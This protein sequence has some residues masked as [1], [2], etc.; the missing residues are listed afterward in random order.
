MIRRGGCAC[1]TAPGAAEIKESG[2][3]MLRRV[4]SPIGTKG[5]MTIEYL[6]TDAS[7]TL[8]REGRIGRI[9]FVVDGEPYVVP[10]NYIFDGVSI[11]AHARLG[12]KIQALRIAPRA[13]L[14]VDRISDDH[15]WSSVLAHGE[16]EEITDPDER[17]QVYRKLLAR[18]PKLTPVEVFED[19]GPP[20]RGAIVFRIR[21]ETV[22]G[23]ASF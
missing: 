14:Q 5:F 17:L 19:H 13:C 4:D 1:E 21:V 15:H 3:C 12:H 2:G 22:T 23:V 18:F 10:V 8:L 9:G 20:R 6:N 16:Y 7:L 11:Y